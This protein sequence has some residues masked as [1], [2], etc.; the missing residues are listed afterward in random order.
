[1]RTAHTW[2]RGRHIY[3][4]WQDRLG[5]QI[6]KSAGLDARQAARLLVKVNDMLA[7]D[8]DPL[9]LFEKGAPHDD[10]TLD[11]FFPVFMERHGNMQGRKTRE[12]YHT[13]MKAIRQHRVS[14]I[15]IR[16][17]AKKDVLAYQDAR[18]IKVSNATVN[19]EVTLIKNMMNR[20]VEWEIIPLSLVEKVK[21][22]P[23][24][25]KRHVILTVEQASELINKLGSALGDVVEF[26]IYTG[27]RKEN[28]LSLMIDQIDLDRGICRIT[29]KG[30][31][32]EEWPLSM[33]AIDVIRRNI[34]KRTKGYVFLSSTG[35]RWKSIN[36]SFDKAVTAL[37]L[38]VNGTKFRFHDLRHV[39]ATWLR[40]AGVSLD[41]VQI[42]MGHS[43]RTTTE[44]YT[45]VSTSGVANLTNLI[46]RIRK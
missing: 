14:K 43:E 8:R 34:G 5:K 42:L 19:R 27:F 23:E 22:L 44:R 32:H 16:L 18:R 10:M 45:T 15:P 4:V 40:D 25:E 3:I 26:A 30:G 37:G 39:Y 1:M 38:T 17:I 29:V 31:R 36:K 6:K 33:L 12:L 35:T 41:A 24:A 11:M 2:K 21:L 20:A 9:G 7:E 46:P 28:I 13:L